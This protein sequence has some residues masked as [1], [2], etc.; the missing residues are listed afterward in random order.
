M[1]PRKDGLGSPRTFQRPNPRETRDRVSC[2]NL[3]ATLVFL[4]VG[5]SLPDSIF[6]DNAPGGQI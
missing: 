4:A 6:V 3:S 5:P 1:T 2:L